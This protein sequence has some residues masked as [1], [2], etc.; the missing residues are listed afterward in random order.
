MPRTIGELAKLT[1][2]SV[3]TLRHYDAIGVL[4]PSARTDAGYRLYDDADLLRLHAIL[5]WRSLGFP[6]DEIRELLDGEG[7]VA[8]ALRTQR[9]RLVEEVE[10]ASGRL[11]ALDAVLQRHEAGQPLIESDLGTLFEGFDPTAHA[12]EAERTWG[13]TDAWREAR[14]R[15]RSYG[16]QEWRVLKAELDA[17]YADLATRLRDGSGPSS[18]EAL[19]LAERHRLHIEKWFYT[20]PPEVHLGLADLYVEDPRFTKNIDRHESGLAS[21]L[22]SAIHALHT[23]RGRRI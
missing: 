23:N 10:A 11:R 8:E 16:P 6:L 2:L 15:T 12:D 17:L 13:H 9:A 5:L 20:C 18:P 3:R 1:Q 7:E 19:Q 22:R 21:Y 4:P 14:E